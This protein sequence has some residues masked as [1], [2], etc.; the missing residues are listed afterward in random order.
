MEEH[1]VARISESV[2]GDICK[3][4]DYQFRLMEERDE[5]R[6]TNRHEMEDKRNEEYYKRID[7]LLRQYSTKNGKPAKISK[8]KRKK[9]EK[10]EKQENDNTVKFVQAKEEALEQQKTDKKQK[11]E[12]PFL[13]RTAEAKIE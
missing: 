12:F 9:L 1:L 7:E 4:L 13:K 8:A 10:M 5:E 11:W 6:V 3:E 2:K